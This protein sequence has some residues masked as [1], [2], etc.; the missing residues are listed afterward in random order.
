MPSI[1]YAPFLPSGVV[2]KNLFHVS[3]FLPTLATLAN[4]DYKIETK[5]DGHDLS[6][7]ITKGEGPFRTDVETFEEVYGVTGLLLNGYKWIN[8]SALNGKADTWLG[9]NDHSDVNKEIYFD[10]VLNSKTGKALRRFNLGLKSQEME[11]IREDVRVK[12]KGIKTECDPLKAPCLFDIDNDPC[13]E[14]NL[15][16]THTKIMKEMEE[17]FKRRLKLVVPAKY[18]GNGESGFYLLI[19]SINHILI[20]FLKYCDFSKK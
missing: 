1:I 15:A 17:E 5:I 12:C 14:N 10:E 3:D 2:R 7:M 4:A 16:N 8:G 20:F 18:V 13:E 6:Q 11:K 9:T 19:R